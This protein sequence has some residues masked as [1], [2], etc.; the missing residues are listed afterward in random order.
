MS[1]SELIRRYENLRSILLTLDEN[2]EEIDA[3]LA[4]LERLLPE[5]YQYPGDPTLE[6]FSA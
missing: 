6:D 5:N 3:E 2:S 1:P 4:E